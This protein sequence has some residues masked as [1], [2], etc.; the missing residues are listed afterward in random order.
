MPP[1]GREMDGWTPT[2]SFNNLLYALDHSCPKGRQVSGLLPGRDSTGPRHE[3]ER[4]GEI[5][6]TKR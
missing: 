4:G 2:L 5:S 1:A 3:E 6:Q